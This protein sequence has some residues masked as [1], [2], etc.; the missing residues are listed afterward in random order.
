MKLG[1]KTIELTEILFYNIRCQNYYFPFNVPMN[2]LI[3]CFL[4]VCFVFVFKYKRHCVQESTPN[5]RYR[6]VLKC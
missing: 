2:L 5:A 3:K 1:P 4:F 6:D